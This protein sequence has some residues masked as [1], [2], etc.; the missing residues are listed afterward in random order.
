MVGPSSSCR[1]S[2]SSPDPGCR[3]R[4]SGRPGRCST[5]TGGC[6]ERRPGAGGGRLWGEGGRA[7][8]RRS[9]SPSP[10]GHAGH[11]RDTGNVGGD[12]ADPPRGHD[13]VHDLVLRGGG[14]PHGP[15]AA[16]GSFATRQSLLRAWGFPGGHPLDHR[17]GLLRCPL[18]GGQRPHRL[19]RAGDRPRHAHDA[20]GERGGTAG[21]GCPGRRRG[22][23]PS[24]GPGHR[25]RYREDLCLDAAQA[26]EDRFGT[27]TPIDPRARR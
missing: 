17:T 8:V 18:R 6:P 5:S 27:F 26:L 21:S 3:S 25:A 12:V 16:M 13:T 14:R 20:G 15:A 10:L 4:R 19:G 2:P 23:T 24:G 11:P 7:A 9:R 22:R 1:G